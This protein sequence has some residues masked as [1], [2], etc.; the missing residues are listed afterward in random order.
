MA[1]PILIV[2]DS[3]TI[4]NIL[5][6]YL[7]NLKAQV[8]EAERGDVALQMVE[9]GSVA[10][11][12]ADISMPGLTGLDLLKAIRGHASEALRRT[13][14]VLLTGDKSEGL[15]AEAQA[16]GADD[17]IHK[18]VSHAE[19]LRVVSRLAPTLGT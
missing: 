18:P 19:L 10:L 4:R 17:F 7:M 15:K 13:P 8:I 3:P 9:Q 12:I 6:I 1:S 16:L 5:R 14:V 11:V 2:D